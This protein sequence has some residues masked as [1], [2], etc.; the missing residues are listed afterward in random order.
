VAA[1]AARITTATTATFFMSPPFLEVF[2][3]LY[4]P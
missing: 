2:A 3:V 4:P 1:R